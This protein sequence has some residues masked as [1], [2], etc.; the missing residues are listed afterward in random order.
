[1]GHPTVLWT[2]WTHAAAIVSPQ[3]CH[4][5][6]GHRMKVG[7]FRAGLLE[8][9]PTMHLLTEQVKSEVIKVKGGSFEDIR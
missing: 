4:L 9:H 5:A 2:T 8:E 6:Q 1:M 3:D 7:I